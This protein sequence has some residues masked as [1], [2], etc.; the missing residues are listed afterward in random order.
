[1]LSKPIVPQDTILLTR[2][3]IRVETSQFKNEPISLDVIQGFM[4]KK[5]EY[6]IFCKPS[7]IQCRVYNQI[8]DLRTLELSAQIDLLKKLC[9]HPV[10]AYTSIQAPER[11]AKNG[12]KVGLSGLDRRFLDFY[13]FQLY[14][15]CPREPGCAK[16]PD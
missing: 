10:L 7:P 1:M 5:V 16:V 8:P 11:Y 15:E 12:R 3:G 14:F 9:N 2:K 13:E 6:I 4:R